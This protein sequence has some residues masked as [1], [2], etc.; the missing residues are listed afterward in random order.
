MVLPLQSI[1]KGF[2]NYLVNY[3]KEII[4]NKVRGQIDSKCIVVDTLIFIQMMF[5]IGVL[6]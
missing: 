6:N 1:I 2:N 3:F 4:L 5:R